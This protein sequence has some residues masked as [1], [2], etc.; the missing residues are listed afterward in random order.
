M[1]EDD[2][3]ADRGRSLEHREDVPNSESMR[4]VESSSKVDGDS[5]MGKIEHSPIDAAVEFDGCLS[6]VSMRT[7]RC[8]K[9]P[10]FEIC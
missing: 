2:S 9:S 1:L 3:D 5:Q 4:I 10:L 8:A 7:S 6:T